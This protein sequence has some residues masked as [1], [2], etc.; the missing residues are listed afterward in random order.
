M[1]EVDEANE[2]LRIPRLTAPQIL[3]MFVTVG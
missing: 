1:V 2:D 3:R